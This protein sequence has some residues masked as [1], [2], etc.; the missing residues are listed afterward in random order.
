MIYME[1]AVIILFFC[2]YADQN[3]KII[4]ILEQIRDKED[5]E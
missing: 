4:K 3:S 1:I 2:L 5:A